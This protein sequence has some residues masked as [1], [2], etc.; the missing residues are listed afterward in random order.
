MI[1]SEQ[2]LKNNDVIVKII[3]YI[4]TDKTFVDKKKYIKNKNR[5]IYD[6]VKNVNN[7]T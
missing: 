4:S 2:L 7:I 6:Y 3:N 5:V 1:Y